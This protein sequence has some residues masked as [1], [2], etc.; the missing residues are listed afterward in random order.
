MHT[1]IFQV[2]TQKLNSLLEQWNSSLHCCF[3]RTEVTMKNLWSWI[4]QY[5]FSSYRKPKTLPSF[6][7]RSLQ[8][9]YLLKGKPKKEI[10]CCSV[11]HTLLATHKIAGGLW[12]KLVCNQK[13][14]IQSY[15]T[16]KDINRRK[17][18][19][20]KKWTTQ[21]PQDVHTLWFHWTVVV[22]SLQSR[23]VRWLTPM[24]SQTSIP[25]Y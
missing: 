12:W 1:N 8:Q 16:L 22:Y 21:H 9:I 2:W 13:P 17:N 7:Y 10:S 18:L 14:E 19:Q 23:K 6:H 15:L 3:L 25:R 4:K 5:P 11:S 24:F 20:T